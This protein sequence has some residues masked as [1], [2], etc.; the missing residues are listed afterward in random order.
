VLIKVLGSAAG[1]GFPQ[2]NCNC[3]N[4]ADVREGLD[5]LRPRTQSSIAVSAGVR[6]FVLLNASPDLRQQI[7]DTPELQ[8]IGG[9]ARSS[10]IKAVVL[11]NGDVDH[12]AGLL[13]MREGQPFTIYATDRVLQVLQSN[14]VFD[15]LDKRIVRRRA[16][17]LGQP[18]TIQG[19]TGFLGLDVEAFAVPGKIALY[20][21]DEQAGETLG[22]EEGDTV[23][24]KLTEKGSGRYFFYIPG[25]AALDDELRARLKRAPLVFF[26]GTLYSDDEMIAQGL[27]N[28]TGTRMGH[29]NMSGP[30]GTLAAFEDLEVGRKIF[31]HVNNSNPAFREDSPERRAIEAAGWEIGYDGME[32]AL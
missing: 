31:V 15:V 11:T 7:T 25:C 22:T 28:K 2:W 16:L 1:G 20:L 10:P 12:V 19:P 23:G 17:A 14:S 6:D 18:F 5:G 29:L 4:C 21:E 8:P 30:G 3:R 24:L 9:S 32:V 13:N 26:D 27:L